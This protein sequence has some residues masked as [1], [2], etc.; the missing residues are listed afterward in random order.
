MKATSAGD[1]SAARPRR[2]RD[3]PAHAGEAAVRHRPPTL[4]LSPGIL[5]PF[6]EPLA[7]SFFGF[8]RLS[9]REAVN[10]EAFLFHRSRAPVR[11][12]QRRR[13]V[14]PLGLRI[15]RAF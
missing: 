1:L 9:A 6:T 10:L 3:I 15:R 7:S 2:S 14:A 4:R 5:L 12:F 11:R 8:T 13:A